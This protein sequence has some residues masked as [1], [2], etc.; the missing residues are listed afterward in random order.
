MST[1][2]KSMTEKM[3]DIIRRPK[4]G[5]NQM[6]HI[7]GVSYHTYFEQENRT[8]APVRGKRKKEKERQGVIVSRKSVILVV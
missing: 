2:Q 8:N 3:K 5:S 4:R 1:D 6:H 7:A